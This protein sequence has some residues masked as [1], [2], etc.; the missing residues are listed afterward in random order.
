MSDLGH[1]SGLQR[2]PPI[3]RREAFRRRHARGI[4]RPE[5]QGRT[6]SS[7]A[8][9]ATSY[10]HNVSHRMSS[11][12]FA[13]TLV[14]LSRLLY[15]YDGVMT[16]SHGWMG[17]GTVS[18]WSWPR[19]RHLLPGM[20]RVIGPDCLM[21]NGRRLDT[22][23]RRTNFPSAF[24]VPIIRLSSVLRRDCPLSIVKLTA[25]ARSAAPQTGDHRDEVSQGRASTPQRLEQVRLG[26]G[27]Q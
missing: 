19:A 2:E 7:I 26:A 27:L 13:R 14:D 18:S 22:L 9:R 23:G 1:R 20:A 10:G 17:E 5:A 16:I 24:S 6:P 15:A 21:A 8:L 11:R 25:A 4:A 3:A 12:P